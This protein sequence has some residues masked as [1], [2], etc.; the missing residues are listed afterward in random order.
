MRRLL[1]EAAELSRALDLIIATQ[2]S[3]SPAVTPIIQQLSTLHR[4]LE[5]VY[6]ES[7]GRRNLSTTLRH[8]RFLFTDSFLLLWKWRVG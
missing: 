3:D 6:E 8:R 4:V 7:T 5:D 1:K 2:G